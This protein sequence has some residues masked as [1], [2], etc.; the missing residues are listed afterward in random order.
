MLVGKC[1]PEAH[2]GSVRYQVGSPSGFLILIRSRWALLSAR[3]L[4]Q[5]QISLG[6]VLQFEQTPLPDILGD[7]TQKLSCCTDCQVKRWKNL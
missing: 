1:K 6:S 4:A 7:G 5:K 2:V 3:S